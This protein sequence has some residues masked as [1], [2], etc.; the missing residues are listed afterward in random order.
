MIY[1]H[2]TSSVYTSSMF[3]HGGY[4]CIYPVSSNKTHHLTKDVRNIGG[5]RVSGDLGHVGVNG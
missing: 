1:D 4:T 3:R 2:V 5:T